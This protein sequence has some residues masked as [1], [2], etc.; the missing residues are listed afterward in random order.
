MP[1]K[2]KRSPK[3]RN[4]SIRPEFR[5]DDV[6]PKKGKEVL[7]ERDVKMSGIPGIGPDQF[8]DAGYACNKCDWTTSKTGNDG[9][10][11]FRAHSKRHV[12]D[13][14]A[15]F[16]SLTLRVLVLGFGL[17]ITALPEFH[18]HAARLVEKRID[19]LD[20]SISLGPP[21]LLGVPL[22][23]SALVFFTAVRVAETGRRAWFRWYRRVLILSDALVIGTCT[24]VTLGVIDISSLAWLLVFV[25]PWLMTLRTHSEISQ[26]RLEVKRRE[27]QPKNF[28]KLIRARES[29]TDVGIQSHRRRLQS[30]I[31]DG[32]LNLASLNSHK[33]E[34]LKRFGLGSAR[35]DKR[36]QERRL[37]KE[38][39][40]KRHNPAWR[41]R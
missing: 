36:K 26:L 13:R 19:V 5:K 22:L 32:R 12:R 9:L 20:V 34:F 18:P 24:S 31:E 30:A 35:L 3:N 23:V 38:H 16:R 21:W 41:S 7:H 37:K 14:R 6:K 25:L 28:S 1:R 27:F 39:R 10:Q 15:K 29:G 33:R 17:F 11:A 8:T 2:K 4:F 40:A